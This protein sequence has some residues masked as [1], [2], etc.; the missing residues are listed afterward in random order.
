[1]SPENLHINESDIELSAIRAQGSGG[2]NVNKVA[3][4]IHCRFDIRRS[5]LPLVYKQRLLNSPDSRINKQGII[6]L[7]AQRFRTQHANKQDAIQRLE[8]FINQTIQIH[9]KRLA[10]KPTKASKIRL[11]ESK[12]RKGNLKSLRAKVRW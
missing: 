12:Q 5:T 7:K 2:Q 1:M 4:A 11:K 8:S 9:K 10:T 6:V 3:T